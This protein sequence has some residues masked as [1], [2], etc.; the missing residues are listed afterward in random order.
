VLIVDPGTVAHGINDLVTASVVIWYAPTDRSEL[1]D[2]LNKRV[3]RPGQR[4]PTTIVQ[5][6]ATQIEE[7]IF[8]RLDNQQA[9]QGLIL[10]F[11]RNGA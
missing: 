1:Y 2:Q 11:A 3:D 10:Q 7:E 6:V 4:V 8:D 5:I 9:M